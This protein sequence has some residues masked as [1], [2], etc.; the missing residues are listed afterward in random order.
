VTQRQLRALVGL[1]WRMIRSRPI[2]FGLRALLPALPLAVA[3]AVAIGK[4]QATAAGGLADTVLTPGMFLSV[5]VLAVVTPLAA[6][7]GNELYPAEQLVAFPVRPGTLVCASLLLSPLNLAWLAQVLALMGVTG[8]IAGDGPW[9]ALAVLT[10][11]AYLAFVAIAGQAVAWLVVGI[12]HTRA[13]RLAVGAVAAA[14]GAAAVTVALTH[15]VAETLEHMPTTAAVRLV[16]QGAEGW[17]G[18]WL[19]GVSVL[20]LGAAVAAGWAVR[21]CGW[22]LS[23]AGDLTGDREGRPVPRRAPAGGAFAE[24]LA[25]DRASISRSAPLRRGVLVLAFLPGA[26]AALTAVEWPSI[27]MLPGLVG[28]GAG[29]L[30][31]VNVFCLDAGGSVWLASLPHDPRLAYLA[32]ARVLAEVCAGTAILS[33]AIAAQRAPSAPTAAQ[34]SA[35]LASTI[36]CTA[37]VVGSCMRVSVRRPHRADLR[38]A[39]DT[40]APPGSMVVYSL[41]LSVVATLTASLMAALAYAADHPWLPLAV[42]VPLTLRPVVALHRA[43]LGWREPEPRARVVA[44]V[45][46]G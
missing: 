28:A 36:A 39:R 12:R 29:L 5:A 8:T 14:G 23:R 26:A 3:L 1:R 22:A 11:L 21:A 24:L 40:P 2:R 27:V 17:T 7:G 41:R 15:R 6:G 43:S 30:F 16:R 13:G 42:A 31:G 34:L 32:K 33:V 46:A 45:S 38:S 18:Q 10:S 35:V 37:A 4:N 20:V 44:A 19:T 25:V 9:W